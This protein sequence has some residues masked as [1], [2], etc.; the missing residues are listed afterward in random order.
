MTAPRSST[1][2]GTA[3][4]LTRRF[5]W[6]GTISLVLA[7]HAACGGSS[8]GDTDSP[9]ASGGSAGALG[10]SGSTSTTAGHNTGTSG[11]SSSSS[12]NSSGGK[13]ATGGQAAAAGDATMGPDEGGAD[14]GGQPG[15]PP[16]PPHE[17]GGA[18]DDDA[19]CPTAAPTD[20][21]E[22]TAKAKCNY[23]ELVCNC[24]GPEDDRTWKCKQ[25]PKPP[26]NM[27]PPMAP[28][29]AAACKTADLPAPACHYTEPAVECQCIDDKW[30]CSEVI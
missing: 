9:T 11:S 19:S 14:A 25:P 1:L 23:P 18:G 16:K 6:P 29:D 3:R 24:D 8:T 28:K 7:A 2:I 20:K 30:V 26:E 4:S 22:C 10:H 27:C 17:M 5:I 21:A 13:Q 15:K 12:G